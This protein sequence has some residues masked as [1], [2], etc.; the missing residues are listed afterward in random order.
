VVNATG[1]DLGEIKDIMIDVP[2]GRVAYVL[3]FGGFSNEVKLFAVPW[4]ALELDENKCFVDVEKSGERARVRQRPLASMADEHWA[5]D[6]HRY[7]GS[8]PYWE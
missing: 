5:T 6:L 8:R 2:T 1:E 7:Y 3:S 4:H